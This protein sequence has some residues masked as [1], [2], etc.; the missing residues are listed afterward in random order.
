M[1]T[2]KKYKIKIQNNKDFVYFV[3]LY[4]I[5]FYFFYTM[6]IFLE[7]ICRLFCNSG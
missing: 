3:F 1:T 6:T 4:F 7:T 5:L 2:L